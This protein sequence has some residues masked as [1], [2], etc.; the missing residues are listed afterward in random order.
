MSLEKKIFYQNFI[1]SIENERQSTLHCSRNQCLLELSP[2]RHDRFLKTGLDRH[3][4]QNVSLFSFCPISKL[5]IR[6]L[7]A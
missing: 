3:H 5:Q 6:K 1:D 7:Q 4:H 2:C